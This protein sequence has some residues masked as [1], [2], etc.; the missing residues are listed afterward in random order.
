MVGR[1]LLNSV[2]RGLQKERMGSDL[3]GLDL[4]TGSLGDAANSIRMYQAL[5]SGL[6]RSTNVRLEEGDALILPVPTVCKLARANLGEDNQ[7]K[8]VRGWGERG[9]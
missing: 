5:E 1:K 4:P 3:H 7:G 8:G 2:Q 6:S 9:R